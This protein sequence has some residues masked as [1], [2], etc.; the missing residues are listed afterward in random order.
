MCLLYLLTAA[1]ADTKLLILQLA[2][3]IES[4][5]EMRKSVL[6]IQITRMEKYY[7]FL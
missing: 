4:L 2:V 6:Q 3:L 7:Y 1:D 5:V